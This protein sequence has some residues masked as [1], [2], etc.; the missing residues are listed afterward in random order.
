VALCL[1][2]IQAALLTY[3]AGF[4]LFFCAQGFPAAL[5]LCLGAYL[6]YAQHNFPAAQLKDRRQWDYHFAAMKSSSMFDMSAPLHWF[7]GNI[8][9]HH[10]HHL[11]HRIPFYRLP[12][13][14][15][16]L[17]ELQS[18]G[19]T[20]WAIRDVVGCLRVA[21]WDPEQQKLV[22]HREANA[23]ITAQAIAAK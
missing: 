11:N 15:K 17:P 18:P 23:I 4:W 13:A 22:S 6:F 1:W 5:S 9:Y 3:F 14:M 10:I 16:A 21:L 19:R 12:E 8:G 7:T 2:W 20:S